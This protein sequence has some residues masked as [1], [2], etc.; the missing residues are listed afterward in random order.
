MLSSESVL[1]REIKRS[2]IRDF[3]CLRL[4]MSQL[5]VPTT[6]NVDGVEEKWKDCCDWK[7]VACENVGYDIQN[8]PLNFK[9]LKQSRLERK[10]W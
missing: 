9:S 6:L 10:E 8:S 3:G 7:C 2:G 1:C 5:N 4:L